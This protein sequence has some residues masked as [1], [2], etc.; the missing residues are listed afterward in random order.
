[1][2]RD[3]PVR[4]LARRVWR[5]TQKDQVTERAAALSYY[6]LFALFPALLFL[7]ALLGYLPVTGLQERLMAYLR[8]VMPPDAASTVERTVSEVLTT[9]RGGLLSI[10]ALVALWA[11]SNG[12]VSIMTTMNAVCDVAERRAW[13][14]RRLIALVLTFGFAIFIVAGLTLMVFGPLIGGAVANRFGFGTE[15]VAAWNVLRFPV[16]MV[17]VLLGIE[18]VYY[19]APA[20]RQGWRWI[21]PGATVALGAWLAMS[22]GLRLWVVNFGNYSATYGSIGGVILLMLWLYLTSVVLL[23]GA[24]ID[25]ELDAAAR[26]R[27]RVRRVEREAA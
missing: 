12:M 26:G 10:G 1:M 25:C 6:F 16:V 19:L 27:A 20:G 15:F 14:K 11:S 18:L 5:E 23:V 9:R 22:Y 7:I 24:E 13:W 17:C 3:L 21:S 2:P 4:E 8:E